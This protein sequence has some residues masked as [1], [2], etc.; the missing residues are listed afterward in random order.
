MT[1]EQPEKKTKKLKK[2]PTVTDKRMTNAIK[3]SGGVITDIAKRLNVSRQAVYDF[4]NKPENKHFWELIRD[5]SEIVGDL[6]ESALIKMLSKRNPDLQTIK[7]AL[8]T[9]F[10]SRGYTM[11]FESVS[12]NI[13]VNQIMTE[14]ESNMPASITFIERISRGEDILLVYGEFKRSSAGPGAG[15]SVSPEVEAK[16]E[17]EE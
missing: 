10:K 15:E 9:K 12:S 1:K 11:K 3:G 6:A 4:L 5:E 7:F 13:D 8:T 2:K 14:L 17:R 16:P